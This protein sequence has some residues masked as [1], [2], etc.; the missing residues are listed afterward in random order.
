MEQKNNRLPVPIQNQLMYVGKQLETT[1]KLLAESKRKRIYEFALKYPDFFV[2]MVSRWHPIPEYLLTKYQN[3]LVWGNSGL[4]ENE[5]LAWSKKLIEK[6]ESQWN[7]DILSRNKGLPWTY[8][9]IDSYDNKWNWTVFSSNKKLPWSIKFIDNYK[10]RF[11]W[12]NLSQNKALPW[13]KELIKK[14]IDKW[15]FEELYLEHQVVTLQELINYIL[16]CN[17]ENLSFKVGSLIYN[18]DA[19]WTL[20]LLDKY[21]SHVKQHFLNYDKSFIISIM[22]GLPWSIEFIEEKKH[23]WDW[24]CLSANKDLPWSTELVD[25]FI[26]KWDW[27]ELSRNEGIPWTLELI[28]KYESEWQWADYDYQRQSKSLSSNNKLPWSIELIKKYQDKWSWGEL[29]RNRAVPWS[30]KLI[31]EFRENI[32]WGR[33]GLNWSLPWS[34]DL[35][36]K[37]TEKWNYEKKQGWKALTQIGSFNRWKALYDNDFQLFLSDDLLNEILNEIADKSQ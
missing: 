21:E 2:K 15:N 3:H 31:E 32:N 1:Q 26:E 34:I 24:R 23:M 36:E 30:M 27:E 8:K 17:S 22:K 18:S 10:G 16:N 33:L 25:A 7:C 12:E 4:S 35:I 13:S 14:Y 5:C 9:F 29:S 28:K 11:D 19:I 6:F 20:E 37:Y